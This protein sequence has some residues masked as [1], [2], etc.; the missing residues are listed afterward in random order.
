MHEKVS[1]AC[2]HQYRHTAKDM[3][4]FFT[5][6]VAVVIVVVFVHFPICLPKCIHFNLLL[7]QTNKQ[8]KKYI[9]K[10]KYSYSYLPFHSVPFLWYIIHFRCCT[11]KRLKIF[12]FLYIFIS[13]K[14]NL[15]A[16]QKKSIYDFL[17]LSLIN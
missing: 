2:F 13:W 1:I 3:T 9:N 8:I 5:A 11:P 15:I 16:F 14:E 17:R 6:A 7:T 12:A 4:D 10:S